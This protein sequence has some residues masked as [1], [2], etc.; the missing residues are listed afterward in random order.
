MF[1]FLSFFLSFFPV[2]MFL[3]F[4]FPSVGSFRSSRA[5]SV[6]I[7][8]SALLV[9]RFSLGAWWAFPFS[10]CCY[11]II[12]LCSPLR[13]ELVQALSRSH[14]ISA[15]ELCCSDTISLLSCMRFLFF[16]CMLFFLLSVF[17]QFSTEKFRARIA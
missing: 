2:R 17:F 5:A 10:R 12:D 14:L 6:A 15:V 3:F 13:R 9:E 16:P 1:F 8:P 4:S 7:L 11:L